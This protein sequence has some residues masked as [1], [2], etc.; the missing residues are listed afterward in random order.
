MIDISGLGGANF[1]QYWLYDDKKSS[2]FGLPGG[3]QIFKKRLGQQLGQLST[4]A[5][6]HG[7]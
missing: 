6:S 2:M 7:Q 5:V 1:M 4:A 3:R